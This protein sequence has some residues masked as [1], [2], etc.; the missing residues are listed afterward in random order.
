MTSSNRLTSTMGSIILLSGVG[1][2]QSGAKNKT[3]KWMLVLLGV[4][5]ESECLLK[6]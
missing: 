3:P 6:A 4:R 1:A 2:D 5:Y